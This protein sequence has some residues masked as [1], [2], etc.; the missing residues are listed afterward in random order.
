MQA[1]SVQ[2]GISYQGVG[3]GREGKFQEQSLPSSLQRTHGIIFLSREWAWGT[4]SCRHLQ[5]NTHLG[6]RGLCLSA[7]TPSVSK[8]RSNESF[9]IASPLVPG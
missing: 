7:D 9:D 4:E 3:T 1:F 8:Q 6:I 2:A 5:K